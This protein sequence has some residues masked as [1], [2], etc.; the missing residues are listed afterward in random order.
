[1]PN[2]FTEVLTMIFKKMYSLSWKHCTT[3]TQL[4]TEIHT[5]G[6]PALLKSGVCNN[7]I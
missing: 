1:M 4:C 6:I 3:A 5:Y 7:I 2:D